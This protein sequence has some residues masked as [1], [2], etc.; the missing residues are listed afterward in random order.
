MKK[1]VSR[2]ITLERNYFIVNTL[3]ESEFDWILAE[4]G[5]SED[6]FDAIDTIDIDIDVDE[7][8]Y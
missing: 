8:E 5:F 2:T 3:G 6:E 7:V 4:L 1:S